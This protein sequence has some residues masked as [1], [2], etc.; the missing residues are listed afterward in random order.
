[1]PAFCA[2]V[3]CSMRGERDNVKFY[4]VPAAL[5][6][7]GDHLNE[8]SKNRRE[9]WIKVLERGNL[10]ETFLKNARICSRHFLSGAPA[11][12]KDDKNIDW[13]PTQYMGY[14]SGSSKNEQSLERYE[15][16]TSCSSQKKTKSTPSPVPSVV[17]EY[18]HDTMEGCSYQ[19]IS[20]QLT[21]LQKE[22]GSHSGRTRSSSL[23]NREC[24]TRNESIHDKK[25]SQLNIKH[26]EKEK[27]KILKRSKRISS[28]T[29]NKKVLKPFVFVSVEM[30]NNR[31][32]VSV[33]KPNRN[34]AALAKS[35]KF[36]D[37][38][39]QLKS[40]SVPIKSKSISNLKSVGVQTDSLS[41]IHPGYENM[42]VQQISLI[43][44]IDYLRKNLVGHAMKVKGKTFKVNECSISFEDQNSGEMKMLVVQ[45][46]ELV[47]S[48]AL[49]I[50][51]IFGSYGTDGLQD[52]RS[53]KKEVSSDHDVSKSSQQY[54]DLEMSDNQSSTS[55]LSCINFDSEKSVG[56]SILNISGIEEVNL[57]NSDKNEKVPNSSPVFGKEVKILVNKLP[58]S[59]VSAIRNGK[60]VRVKSKNFKNK[61]GFLNSKFIVEAEQKVTPQNSSIILKSFSCEWC[62]LKFPSTTYLREHM[63]VHEKKSEE[64]FKQ[65]HKEIINSIEVVEH[66]EIQEHEISDG[67]H[68]CDLCRRTFNYYQSYKFHKEIVHGQMNVQ[69]ESVHNSKSYKNCGKK[70]KEV[71]KEEC[72]EKE[73]SEE[74][75]PE[76]LGVYHNMEKLECHLLE[77]HKTVLKKSIYKCD[78]CSKIFITYRSLVYHKTKTHNVTMTEDVDIKLKC[79]KCKKLIEIKEYKLVHSIQC[80]KEL[81]QN[82]QTI[83]E[84]STGTSRDSPS[85]N[86]IINLNEEKTVV[87]P[88]SSYSS[89]N[90]SNNSFSE[91]GIIIKRKYTLSS[92][93]DLENE[94]VKEKRFKQDEVFG[95]NTNSSHQI[96]NRLRDLL[97]SS[98]GPNDITIELDE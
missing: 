34:Q 39:S 17:E 72:P 38:K 12:L 58:E 55:E 44:S 30:K 35:R 19:V 8:L 10:S 86:K 54:S 90:S 73:D 70:Y 64:M 75:C 76:C 82:N 81:E 46:D 4:R 93:C 40:L 59:L 1:M 7:S 96:L 37:S 66:D 25:H 51:D 43:R 28:K 36:V 91:N 21:Q 24:S 65:E 9:S 78:I 18:K 74:T 6:N 56:D 62:E 88:H 47:S 11:Q 87:H 48:G 14:I 22:Y 49:L 5:K 31:T 83:M 60:R 42:D 2:V 52:S 85:N 84:E 29:R 41:T 61:I 50:K 33:P 71:N 3:G 69:K 68:I 16:Y 32:K 53:V 92:S 26:P 45:P 27:T 57:I 79:P 13:I 67:N 80:G 94:N 97:G 89:Q 23:I 77:Y 15:R 20:N 95:E 63:R 98:D